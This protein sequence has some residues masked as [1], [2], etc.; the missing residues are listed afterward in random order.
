MSVSVV[1]LVPARGGS[2]RIVGKNIRP[3][4]GHPLLA[5]TV[6]A[7]LR[8]G[9]FAEV[10]VSTDDEATADVARRYGAR[11]PFM[12]PAELAADS[13][14]DIDWVRHALD[15]LRRGGT[16]VDVFAILRPTSPL[17]PTASIT[18]AVD[19]LLVDPD[20]DSLRA[21]ERVTEHP[22]KMWVVD[23]AR[24]RMSPLLD[25][26]GANPPWHSTP[27]Q[28]LPAV[29]VQNAS[30]EVAWTRTVDDLGSIAG[31]VVKPWVTASYDGFDLNHETDWL[32]LER[33][34]D[35]GLAELEEPTT[36]PEGT[37]TET[38]R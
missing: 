7:A 12:R 35:L 4:R 18:A 17:R 6:S 32:L 23:D 19:A 37:L 3:L 14:A 34:L 22:G 1:A 24:G 30:L 9:V 8:S 25:D 31:R 15:V 26:G 13:S 10:V 38:E 20:A 29:Y 28:A 11:L 16:E 27:Y 2:K 21:V 36:V 33:L 5:Y